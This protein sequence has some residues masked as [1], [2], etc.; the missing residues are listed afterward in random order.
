MPKER[1]IE[2]SNEALKDFDSL[3]EKHQDRVFKLIESIQSTPFKGL[4]SL[5]V[6]KY[7]LQRCWSRRITLRDR[8]VYSVDD[9]RIYIYSCKY[10]YT[11]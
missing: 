5:E 3:T 6:L 10:H 7:D 8:L 2:F 11:K 1:K 4:G 9:E